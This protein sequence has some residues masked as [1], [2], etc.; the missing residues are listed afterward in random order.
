ML[1]RGTIFWSRL[2]GILGLELDRHQTSMQL[3]PE[4]LYRVELAELGAET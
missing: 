4:L 3:D 2:H 1:L